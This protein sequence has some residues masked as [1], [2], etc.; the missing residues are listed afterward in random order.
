MGEPSESIQQIEQ[1]TTRFI[2]VLAEVDAGRWTARPDA[3]HWSLSEVV[4]HV[5]LTN[6][7]IIVRLGGLRRLD[8]PADITD[9]EMPYLFYRGAEPPNLA[10]PTGIWTDVDE[11][12]AQLRASA[13]ALVAWADG[14]PLD[15]RAHGVPHPV[16]GVL[17]GA[18]WLRFAAVHTWRHRA[19]LQAVR[20]AVGI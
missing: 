14:T 7:G 12:V 8:A 10:R 13:S 2:D 11:A 9:E 3:D 19:E 1:A 20:Q 18:Q 17:D 15:L 5:T 16:F 6:R 4:E